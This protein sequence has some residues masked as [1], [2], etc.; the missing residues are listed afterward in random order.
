MK[1]IQTILFIMLCFLFSDAQQINLNGIV[2]V[3]NSKYQTGE[4]QY[5]QDAEVTADFTSPT[6]SDSNGEFNLTFVSVPK[7]TSVD[8]K[9]EKSGWEIVNKRELQDVVVGRR[10]P[11]KIFLAKKGVLAQVQADLYKVSVDALT[12]RHDKLIR[13]LKAGGEQSQAVIKNLEQK[14]STTIANR[15]EAEGLLNKQL[16]DT[17]NRLPEFA[18]KLAH[19]NL[20]FASQMYRTAYEYF[21][22]GEIEKAIETLD[23]A[24]LDEQALDALFRL[25]I[26]KESLNNLDIALT[27]ELQNLDYKIKSMIL[28]AESYTTKSDYQTAI[29]EYEKILNSLEQRATEHQLTFSWIYWELANIYQETEQVEKELNYRLKHLQTTENLQDVPS[30]DLIRS[31][32]IISKLYA[33]QNQFDESISYQTKLVE[34]LTSTLT[35][36][37]PN[38]QK[39]Q[40]VL[41]NLLAKYGRNLELKQDNAAALAIYERLYKLRPTDKTLKKTIKKLKK[42]L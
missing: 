6:S 37:H 9:V 33:A 30:D 35:A 23:E 28:I 42:K 27:S 39:Q 24:V 8:V 25:N 32:Q 15:F 13:E 11:L 22:Q 29:G 3:H 16:E 26:I 21:I 10:M 7:G 20:D 31:Y 18:K 2:T 34:I 36:N 17:K 41:E 40:I 12:T 4:I 19:K 38:T 1:K 14:L 5:F